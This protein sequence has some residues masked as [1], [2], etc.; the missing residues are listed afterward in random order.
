MTDTAT[1]NFSF[2]Y[3]FNYRSNIDDLRQQVEKLGDARARLERSVD[4][5]IRNGDEIEADVDKWLLRLS[6]EAKKRAR[7]V[8]EIQGDGK[9]ERVSYRVP[10]SGIGSAPFKGHEALESRMTTLDEIMEALRD[11]HVNI[12]GVWGMASV[13]KTTLMKQVAKQAEEEKLFDKVVMAYISSTPEL[14]KIQ[15]ELADMLGLKFEEESEMG[16]AAR[17]CE[18][19]KKVKKILIILDDIWTELDLEKVGIPFGDDHKGCKMVLTSRNKHVLSNEMGTQKD[20]PVEH[21]QEEEALILF[22]KM[23][24]DSI[25]EP[26]LQSIAIDVAKECAGMDAMVYSTLE[27]SYKHLE[28]DEVKSL[29]LLCGLMFNK[30]YIDDL[31]KYGMG[32]QLFQGTN[33]LEE[34]KNRIDTLVD[35]L[36]ASK[37]LLDIGHNSFVRMHDVVRD[38]AIA[39]VSKVHHVFSLREDEL[40]EWPK[41]DE[42]QTCTKISL[43]Y[44]DICELP[45]GLLPREIAQ[46]THLRLFDLRGCSKLGEIPPIVI[47]SLS[48]LENLCMENSFTLWEVEGKSNAS[49]AELKY[50]PHLTTLDIQI[51]DA[52][53][54]LTDVLFEK[55]IRYRIFIGDVWSWDKNCPTTKTLKLSKLNTS[56]HLADGIN[57]LL[58]GAKDL[59]LCELSV[60]RSPEMQHIMNSMD[61]ILSPYAFPVLESL[62]LNQLINLQEV[63]HGQLLVG[64]FS[65]LR[66]VKVEHCDG[67]KFLFSMSMARGLSRLEKIEIPRC[68][69]MYKMVAQ[70]KEDGDDA[71]DA[72]LFTEVRYLTLQHLP[73]F[74]NFCLE[75]KTMP[76]TTK[77]SPTTNVRFNSICSEGELDNQTSVFNNWTCHSIDLG[78][79]AW[80]TPTFLLQPPVPEDKELCFTVE[81]TPTQFASKLTEF[82]RGGKL[83]ETPGVIYTKPLV[84]RVWKVLEIPRDVHTSLHYGGRHGRSPRLSRGF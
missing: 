21:L 78:G 49:I 71:V 74:R 51:P 20:F 13:G 83:L 3:L 44:N 54:L 26:D 73:K 60:E 25:E 6:R 31:L 53:L 70:G 82:G 11:A 65:Y 22:K 59:H 55:L 47:S 45:I 69:N 14:K 24:G 10:L 62:F 58:K 46:L 66:I 19:L 8:A 84:G 56:L 68:K 42:L 15:G 34:A 52:K 64:S 63:C 79:L 39:I 32:L 37:L 50:L 75:G 48:K 4:E 81:S 35:S 43:A 57:L 17:L 67:L 76:S 29:F 72:I 80:S 28:G 1:L 12:I 7:F 30:I 41:M 36:K 33:T 23:A 27:L 61:P 77:R 40:A 16:R 5:A 38:V 2:G 9:F 18:R